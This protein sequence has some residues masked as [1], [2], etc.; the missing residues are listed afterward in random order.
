MHKRFLIGAALTTGVLTSMSL[1]QSVHGTPRA[2][3]ILPGVARVCAGDLIPAQYSVRYADGTTA[4]LGRG[5]LASL[6]RRSDVAE[7]KEDGSWLTATNPLYAAY[8][9]YRLSAVL[10]A[11]TTVRGDTVV[12][13]A[14]VCRHN[15]IGLGTSGR[16]DVRSAHVRLGVLATPFFDSIVVAVVEPDHG[17]PMA[18]VLTPSEIQSGVIRILAPGLNGKDGRDGKRGENGDECSDGTP[19]DDGEPGEQGEAGGQVNIIVQTDAPWLAQLVA[20]SNPGG[21][22]GSG[23]RG[24]QGGAAGLRA[25]SRAGCNPRMGRS[26]RNGSPGPIGA[27]GPAPQTTTVLFALLWPGSPIWSD[28][29]AHRALDALM[30]YTSQ[31]AR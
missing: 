15:P 4:T 27:A 22:G 25:R 30:E 29:L 7:P 8:T 5:E 11:D 1:A 26:G 12:P 23:G 16:F 14:P 9:G 28:A 10:A 18:S 20:V 19:G 31:R 3:R 24:G 17:P 2:I 13:P 6:V 21:R